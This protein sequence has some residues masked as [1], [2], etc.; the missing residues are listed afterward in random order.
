MDL[1][2]ILIVVLFII[3]FGRFFYYLLLG[4]FQKD[5][6]PDFASI[7]GVTVIE[8]KKQ[9]WDEKHA[10]LIIFIIVSI[11]LGAFIYSFL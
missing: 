6:E 1:I 7:P 10:K 9:S 2:W 8:R 3:A 5:K 11:L 4:N